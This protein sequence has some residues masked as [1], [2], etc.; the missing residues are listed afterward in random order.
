MIRVEDQGEISVLHME[1]GR[2]N[3]LDLQFVN[4]LDGALTQL[5]AG[6]ARAVVITGQERN[7]CAGV[8][9]ASI[10]DGGDGATEEFLVALVRLFRHAATFEK[11]AVAAVNGHAIAG[12][13]ILMLACDY[14]LIAEGKARIGLT[15]LL[16][17]VPFPAW[18][19]EIARF[20]IPRNHVQD[21]IYTGRVVLP[22]EALHL[23]LADEVSPPD[24]LLDRACDVARQ[25]ARV[26][27][28]TFAFTKR[29]LRRELVET[30][31]RQAA[32][33]DRHAARIWASP[34]AHAR[35]REFIAN[36]IGQKSK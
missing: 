3:A 8:D 27:P 7:F 14:R 1:R 17:G 32:I 10:I 30:A 34:E 33:D 2:A 4:A 28:E 13:C 6:P 18:A 12:G 20:G 11:P 35:I 19:M 26:A 29:Q 5:E 25:F 16:V 9:L 36:V 21:L 31:D 15:E 22:D 24:K 23:G